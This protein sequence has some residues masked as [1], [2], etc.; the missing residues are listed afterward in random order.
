MH[1][2]AIMRAV[3]CQGIDFRAYITAHTSQH[4]RFR[5]DVSGHTLQDTHAHCLTLVSGHT[6]QDAHSRAHSLQLRCTDV[7]A[8]GLGSPMRI[9]WREVRPGSPHATVMCMC[10]FH[11]DSEERGRCGGGGDEIEKKR[12]C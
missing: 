4:F 9:W 12:A 10:G 1:F 8:S 2:S 6:F 7:V 11:G 5:T 3:S